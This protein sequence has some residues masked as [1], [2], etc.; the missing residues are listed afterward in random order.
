MH[1]SLVTEDQLFEQV[2]YIYVDVEK[3]TGKFWKCFGIYYQNM[4]KFT[5][6]PGFRQLVNAQG[7]LTNGPL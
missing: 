6:G 3:E 4:R 5:K 7:S 1:E 2:Q